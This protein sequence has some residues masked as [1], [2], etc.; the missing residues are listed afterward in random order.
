MSDK[1]IAVVQKI[2][3][4][5]GT[6]DVPGILEHIAEDMRGFGVVSETREIPWHMQITRKADVP[7]FFQALAAECDFTRF[8]PRDFAASGDQVYCTVS[9]DVTIRRNGR[10]LSIDNTMHRFTLKN[11]RVVEWRGSEDTDRVRKALLG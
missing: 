5:F 2:Y 3:Q 10:K 9:Y 1:N 8:E 11:G 4:A 7:S 6:G